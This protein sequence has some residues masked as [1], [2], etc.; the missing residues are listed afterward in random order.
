MTNEAREEASA[1]PP[2]GRY[3]PGPSMAPYQGRRTRSSA[4]E[5]YVDIV[6]VTGSIPVASTI[7][8]YHSAPVGRAQDGTR[9]DL[10]NPRLARARAAAAARLA[11]SGRRVTAI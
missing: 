5:H 1:R 10:A 2:T 3:M 8:S 11:K 6:G 9:L 7:F 4:V